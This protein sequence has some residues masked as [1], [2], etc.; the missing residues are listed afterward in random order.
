[1]TGS[2]GG[3][4]HSVG[5]SGGVHL[6]DVAAVGGSGAGPST[7]PDSADTLSTGMGIIGVNGL[8]KSQQPTFPRPD[9]AQMLP[10]KPKAFP[11]T[12]S[13]PVEGGEFPPPAAASDLLRRLPPPECFHGPFVQMDRFLEHFLELEIPQGWPLLKIR[14]S[15]RVRGIGRI[16]RH[17]YS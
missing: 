11:R 17:L 4:L 3:F 12:D 9:F 2:G 13:H 6:D 10:F 16:L 5:P 8:P 15:A 1:M 14:M 7:L